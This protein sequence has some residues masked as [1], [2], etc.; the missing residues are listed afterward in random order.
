MHKGI[1]LDKS[2][3]DFLPNRLSTFGVAPS[4]FTREYSLL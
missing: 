1:G 2:S 3:P 4:S